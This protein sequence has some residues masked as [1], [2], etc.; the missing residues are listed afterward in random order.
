MEA[1][2]DTI[3]RLLNEE[4]DQHAGE[5]NQM[6][7]TLLGVSIMSG[8]LETL[9]LMKND[10][11][12]FQAHVDSIRRA[13]RELLDNEEDLRLLYLTKVYWVLLES[14]LLHVTNFLSFSCIV[15]H[16]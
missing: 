14:L 6:L 15:I 2:L 12:A 1:I 3:E 5:I 8:E 16:P 11:S 4:Y 13:I 7:D 10:M 9:R